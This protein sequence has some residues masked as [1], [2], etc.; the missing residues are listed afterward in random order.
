MYH[1]AGYGC[2]G[3]VWAIQPLNYTIE[4][5]RRLTTASTWSLISECH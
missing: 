2:K 4:C 3:Q 5:L 1:G